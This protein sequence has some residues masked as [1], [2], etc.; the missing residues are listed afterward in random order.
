MMYL[1]ESGNVFD[2]TSDVLKQ[3][4]P[5]VVEIARRLLPPAL[6]SQVIKDIGSAGF[7]VKSGD[8]DLFIDQAVTLKNYGTDDPTV[9]KK[10]LQTHL[11]AQK[12][13]AVVKGRNVHADIPYKT[14][15]GK[16]A[17]AQVDFMIIPDAAKVAD[18]HQHGPR[19]MYDDPNFKASQMFILLNSIGKA[20]GVKV[21]AFGGVVMRRDNNEVVADNR[22]DAAKLLLN[23]KARAEDL[24]SV[25]TIMKALQNDPDREAKLAQ[26]RQDQAKGLLTLP[27]DHAPGTAAWFRRL[28]HIV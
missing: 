8:I 23:P 15:E 27:E 18:W 21:D 28:G 6:Q 10:A 2:N 5:T 9:A 26:A 17:F 4:V 1:Y 14:A 19:G 16:E 20:L 25:A 24:N 22:K 11:S 7:K 3:D 12:I 13:P